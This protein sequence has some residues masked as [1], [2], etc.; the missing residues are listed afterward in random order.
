MVTCIRKMVRNSSPS[1][2]S[3]IR[4]PRP[5]GCRPKFHWASFPVVYSVIHPTVFVYHDRIL[6]FKV[7]YFRNPMTVVHG[8]NAVC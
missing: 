4:A 5:C 2:A 3:R 6:V 8:S 1:G 7:S